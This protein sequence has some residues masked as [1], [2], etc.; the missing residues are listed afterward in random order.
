MSFK[1][2]FDA[3]V[4]ITQLPDNLNR[5][6]RP[7]PKMPTR[8][9]NLVPI[10]PAPEAPHVRQ[11][12]FVDGI[13]DTPLPKGWRGVHLNKYDGT[14]DTD[15]HLANYIT[16]VNLFSNE[17]GESYMW[18]TL[19]IR[20]V[21]ALRIRCHT[22][23]QLVV[24]HIKGTYQVKDPLFLRYYQ[25]ARTTLQRFDKSEDQHVLYTNNSRNDTLII[26]VLPSLAVDKPEI[27]HAE[28]EDHEWMT[29]IW[30][31]LKHGTSPED[32]TNAAKIR[33][34]A[35]RYLIEANHLYKRGF[36]TPY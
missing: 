4:P 26:Q 2:N 11:H 24:E 30:N 1:L 34:M 22:D 31:Y 18:T 7:M 20:W 9:R 32:K 17:H 23:S 15:E 16:Q 36:S 5:L 29:P 33:Q 10:C 19:Q 13:M 35:N 6:G 27:V 21:N 28:A 12:P 14:I 3:Q 8:Q 25:W